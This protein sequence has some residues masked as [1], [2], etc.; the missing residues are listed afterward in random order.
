MSRWIA[1]VL[2]MTGCVSQMH[3]LDSSWDGS[4]APDCSEGEGAAAADA[5][6]GQAGFELSEATGDQH[7]G[8]GLLSLLAGIGFSASS[9]VGAQEVR[10]CHEANAEWRLSQATAAAVAAH[11]AQRRREDPA[12]PP[13]P[14]RGYFCT[15]SATRVEVGRCTRERAACEQ[16]RGLAADAIR[17]LSPCT[18]VET[19]TCFAGSC[20]PS[21][22]ACAAHRGPDSIG[23]C[24]ERP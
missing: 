17:D 1:A 4:T 14:P 7:P 20:Y 8:V 3:R 11:D 22:A 5:L 15:A 23:D 6:L 2:C 19:A 10:R 24:T 21:P 18:L 13:P 9:A 16:A 12:P